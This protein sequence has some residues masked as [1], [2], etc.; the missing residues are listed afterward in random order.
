[1]A[2]AVALLL[3]LLIMLSGCGERAKEEGEPEKVT[4]QKREAAMSLTSEAFEPGGRIPDRYT[5]TGEDISPPLSLEQVSADAE[6]LVLILDDPDAPGGVFDH[7]L[8]W[9]IPADTTEIP[10]GIPQAKQ[11][12]QLGGAVQGTND[13]NELGYRGPCPPAGTE[14]EYRF[15]LYALDKKLELPPGSKRAALEQAMEGH[16][17]EEGTLRGVY[18]R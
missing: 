3:P 12:E 14:H 11:V 13:F 6:S 9:N 1:M 17:L 18:S 4:E 10:E 5:C 16:V 7:W 2:I 15:Q 8:L